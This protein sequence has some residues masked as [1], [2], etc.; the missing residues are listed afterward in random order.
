ME[1]NNNA[2]SY[3]E[4]LKCQG[5]GKSLEDRNKIVEKAVTRG[6]NKVRYVGKRIRFF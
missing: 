2:K 1:A 6:G 3:I 4:T 5:I